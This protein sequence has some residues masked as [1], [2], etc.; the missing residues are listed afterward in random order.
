[1]DCT[2]HSANNKLITVMA[3]EPC[4]NSDISHSY[5]YHSHLSCIQSGGVPSGTFNMW[6]H[7]EC[8][9]L[10]CDCDITTLIVCTI[11]AEVKWGTIAMWYH[12]LYL[13]GSI[14]ICLKR[15]CHHFLSGKKFVFL[16]FFYLFYIL[17]NPSNSVRPVELGTQL[18]M[19]FC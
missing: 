12:K 14:R 15:N 13:N 7:N 4:V 1:M 19:Q 18:P 9:N 8:H 5:A 2:I 10:L 17:P 6:H 11:K 3:T 16:I